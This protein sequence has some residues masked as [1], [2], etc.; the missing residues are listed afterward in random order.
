M[1]YYEAYD[2]RLDYGFAHLGIPVGV[3]GPLLVAFSTRSCLGVSNATMRL[4][5]TAYVH[6]RTL[7]THFN[8]S[9]IMMYYHTK[10]N[11]FWDRFLRQRRRGTTNLVSQLIVTSV[12]REL[13]KTLIL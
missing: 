10:V 9:K 4:W 11:F 2:R 13:L 12:S 3:V 1:T 7:I 6:L 8:Q 5:K